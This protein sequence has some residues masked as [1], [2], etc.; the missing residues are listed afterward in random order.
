MKI[1][2]ISEYFY[3]EPLAAAFRAYDNAWLW[4]RSGKSVTVFTAYPIYPAG[5]IHDGYNVKLLQ[6]ELLTK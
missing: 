4:Q 6:E 1:L 3:P 2:Y 5:K